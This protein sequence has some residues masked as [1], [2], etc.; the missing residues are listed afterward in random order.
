[1]KIQPV[2]IT[3]T[4]DIIKNINTSLSYGHEGLDSEKIKLIVDSIAAPATFIINKSIAQSKFPSRWKLGRIIPL[5]KGGGIRV[6][7]YLIHLGRFHY[8]QLCQK[9]Q[10]KL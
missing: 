9:L 4:K 7:L 2:S 8:F 5:H 6:I 1:M 10:R 3:Q